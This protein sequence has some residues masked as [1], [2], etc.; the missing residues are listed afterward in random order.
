MDS[1][2]WNAAISS[3]VFRNYATSELQKEATE[4]KTAEE[5]FEIEVELLQNFENFEKKVNTSPQLKLAFQKLQR[6]FISDP[7]YTAKVHPSFVE[8]VMMLKLEDD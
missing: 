8:G 4:N 3:E 5:E 2:D 7:E 1:T 6:T